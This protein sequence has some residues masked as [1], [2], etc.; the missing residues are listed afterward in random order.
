MDFISKLPKSKGKD[1]IL[2]VVD[3]L[4]K[5]AYSQWFKTTTKASQIADVFIKDIHKLRKTIYTLE[6]PSSSCIHNVFHVS[7]LN[8]FIGQHMI[9]QT[10]IPELD[11]EGKLILEQISYRHQ[12]STYTPQ[13]HH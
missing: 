5:Y 13:D 2:V 9:S 1:V 10:T 7:C 11:N 12:K 8:K 3:I 4:T 6:L